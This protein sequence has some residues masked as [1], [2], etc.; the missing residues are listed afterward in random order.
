MTYLVAVFLSPLYFAMK[1]RW[2]AFLV[3]SVFYGIAVI[4][5]LTLVGAFLA[6][7]PW[8]IAAVHA[9]M[10]Y[11]KQLVDEAATVMAKKMVAALRDEPLA[12]TKGLDS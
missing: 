12:K 3:N 2:W 5:L 8:L 7:F 1:A 9:I 4:L 10:D 11:R 6:P